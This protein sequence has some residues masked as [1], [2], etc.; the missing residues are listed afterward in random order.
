MSETLDPVIGQC[1]K[2]RK[3][4]RQ[5][6]TYVWCIGG[7]LLILMSLFVTL[8]LNRA[9]SQNKPT[10]RPTGEEA[11][12]VGVISFAGIPP[13]PRRFDM[14]ADPIC[15]TVSPVGGREDV[16]V[17]DGKVANVF[18]YARTGDPLDAFQFDVSPEEVTLEHK[19]CNYVPHVLG[20]QT[21]QILKIVNSDP[22]IHN[23]HAT[24]KLNPE[25]SQSQPPDAPSVEK[26]FFR[27]ELFIPIKDNQHPWEKAYIGVLS[28]P[29]FA[30]SSRDGSYKI[31]GLPPGQYTIVAW[32]E[33]YGEQ[34]ADVSIGRKE[35]KI[36]DFTVNAPDH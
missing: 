31:A 19:G 5:S 17:T 22:T 11:S 13:E 4:I 36:L 23:T 32:H 20:I 10:Y 33:K 6:H 7:I 2:C 1:K 27:S 3:E 18:V 29:F 14:S 16:I 15:E 8:P 12:L 9:I 24:P 25:W 21:Q 26:R 28:H 35:Q 30:V 34:T